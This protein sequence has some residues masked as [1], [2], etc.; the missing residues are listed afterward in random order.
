MEVALIVSLGFIVFG[1]YFLMTAEGFVSLGFI[2]F[3]LCFPIIAEG[4][5]R[6]S[7]V[8]LGFKA[9]ARLSFL[10]HS[11]TSSVALSRSLILY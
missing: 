6:P 5:V 7:I 2:V 9:L 8:S 1:S 4:F 11:L 3:G 10:S